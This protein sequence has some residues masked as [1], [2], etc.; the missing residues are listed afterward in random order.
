MNSELWQRP[1]KGNR[2]TQVKGPG[3]GAEGGRGA[4]WGRNSLHTQ[5]S[6]GAAQWL[7]IRRSSSRRAAGRSGQ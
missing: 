2:G 6:R 5:F 3:Q 1:G 4:E 7:G